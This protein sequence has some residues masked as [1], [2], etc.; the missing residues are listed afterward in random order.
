MTVSAETAA[1]AQALDA[2]LARLLA[3]AGASRTT[4]RLD[5]ATH[6]WTVAV[7]CAE[8]LAPGVASM[9]GD[10]SIN[11]R[12]ASTTQWIGAHRRN[13]LQ[14]NLLDNPQPPPPPAL[15]SAYGAKAQMLGPLLDQTGWLAGWISA[16]YI[17]GPHPLAESESQAMDRARA[18]IAGLVG[19]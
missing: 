7:V 16:H 14:P 15:L 5:S 3:E 19:L 2:V 8:A 6:G 12:A 18:E 10:G 4:L 1:L 9:R 11:Q 17:D 13:L